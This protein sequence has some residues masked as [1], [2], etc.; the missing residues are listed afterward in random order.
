[1]GPFELMD[2]TGLD[3]TAAVIDSIWQGFRHEDR[4]RP[5]YLTPNRV[6]A[7]LHGRKTGQGWF[8]YGSE[9]PGPDAEPPV[10]GDADRP[11]FMA[12]PAVP[13]SAA[14]REALA[15]AGA[16]VETGAVPSAGALV[17]VP[18]WGTTAAAAVASL[19]LPPGA[20][21]AWTRCPPRAAAGCSR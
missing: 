11:L 19:G 20:P 16:A 7:K 5:S 8:A 10:T 18:V 6:T 21:S 4:L 12:G 13:G 3:V 9:A 1:M 17:L 2:L 15:S 14:L